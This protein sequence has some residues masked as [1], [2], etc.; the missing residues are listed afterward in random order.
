MAQVTDYTIDNATGAAVRTDLNNVFGAIAT[1]NSGATEPTTTYAYMLWAD[2]AN[3]LLKI[4]NG[5]NSAWITVGTLDATNLGLIANPGTETADYTLATDGASTFSWALRHRS[6]EGTAIATTSGSNHDFSSLPAYIK[7]ITITLEG[8]STDGTTDDLR[9][10]IGPIGGVETTGYVSVSSDSTGA[11]IN[12]DAAATA[13]FD[14]S[15]SALADATYSGILTLALVDS[16][17]N[18]WA[19][20]GSVADTTNDRISHVAGTKSLANP[21]TIVSLTLTGTPTDAF[22][23]GKVNIIYEG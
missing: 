9:I 12:T 21:L 18:T 23:A 5:A 3:T 22:D 19:I 13:G 8:V 17:A 1:S 20:S 16:S 15:G 2:T 11:T 7:R 10:R 6:T 4:R 14:I